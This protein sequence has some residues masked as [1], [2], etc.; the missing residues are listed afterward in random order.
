MAVREAIVRTRSRY[1]S[2]IRA[3]VRRDGLCVAAGTARSFA[4][5]LDGLPLS[6]ELRTEVAPLVTVALYTGLRRGELFDLRWED[7]IDFDLGVVRAG[8]S[9]TESGKRTVPMNSLVLDTFRELYERRTGDY[10]FTS[11]KTGGRLVDVKTGFRKACADAKI[12]NFVF[13][14]LRHTFGTRLADAGVDV[15]KI[16]EL[17]GHSSITTTMRYMHAA[18]RREEGGGR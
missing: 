4:V 5:R 12:S 6:A 13:H 11:P 15:V 18:G 3:L 14:D 2:L 17:M 8:R 7:G 9:K 16:K 10:V 1:I